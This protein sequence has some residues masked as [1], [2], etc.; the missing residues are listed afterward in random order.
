[1]GIP[2]VLKEVGRGDRVALAK[3]AIEH[4]EHTQRPLRIAI[5][6]AIWNFQTQSGQGGKNPALR[7]LYYR[8][9]RLL[10]LPIHPLFVYD[11][12]DKPLS[13]RGHTVA[14]YGSCIANE[15]SKR[16]IQQ[17]RFPC[18]SAPGEAEAE[19]AQLQKHGIVDMVMSQDGDAIMFGSGVTLRNWSKEAARGNHE[20]THVD[21]LNLKKI[22]QGPGLDPDGMILVAMLSGG[23]YDQQGLPGFGVHMACDIARAGFGTDLLEAIRTDD[24]NALE[25]WRA[26]LT[27]ELETN[28]S[29]YFKKRHKTLKIP[30]TFPDRK[31]L[32][33]YLNPAIST[34]ETLA[35]LEQKW[36][37]EWEANINIPSL[38]EYV[39]QIFDWQYKPGA[40][41]LVRTMTRP[42]LANRLQNGVVGS[43][44]PSV[45][46]I[47]ERRVHYTTGGI[48]EL[49]LSVI[50]VDVV[51]LDLEAEQDSPE[52]LAALEEDQ[53]IDN[54]EELEPD[55]ATLEYMAQS[56]TKTKKPRWNPYTAEKIWIAET[57]VELGVPAIVEEWNQIQRE[58]VEAARLKATRKGRGAKVKAGQVRQTDRID[59]YFAL[60]RTAAGP[61]PSKTATSDHI[62]HSTQHY[63]NALA[64]DTPATPTKRRKPEA[65]AVPDNSPDLKQYFKPAKAGSRPILDRRVM[66]SSMDA[67]ESLKHS[68]PSTSNSI[69]KDDLDLPTTP[70]VSFSG[71]IDNPIALTSSPTVVLTSDATSDYSPPRTPEKRRAGNSGLSTSPPVRGLE[72]SVTQRK[73]RRNVRKK[74]TRSKTEGDAASESPGPMEKFLSPR[75][76]RLARP[77][78]AAAYLPD[79]S[80]ASGGPAELT[81]GL[82]VGFGRKK[83]FAIPRE[84]LEGT[85]KE[86]NMEDA[87]STTSRGGGRI[88]CVNLDDA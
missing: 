84:S 68:R 40:W 9:L 18:H 44:V 53:E 10:A 87:V 29:G 24:E 60:T 76:A 15:T 73:V 35:R 49:R 66:K 13:K 17:F 23:D 74:L 38:R 52:N 47:H 79:G 41:K 50:P 67:R 28:E 62:S 20:P 32:D 72:D 31:I 83:V 45:E 22:K 1:M 25:D 39:G 51:G 26:R 64:S 80:A 11:G 2:G 46:H 54:G 36:V 42:L 27:Y 37:E 34:R 81:T 4:L 70:S 16:L 78:A 14:R 48:P 19:C 69:S 82:K 85:W 21:L 75:K 30:E 57:Q 56:P 59:Q 12:K 5:D 3:L 71:S 7:T 33:C 86:L 61:Q 88:S 55:N 58:K 6:A 63:E 8:L 43:L 77:V 65:E